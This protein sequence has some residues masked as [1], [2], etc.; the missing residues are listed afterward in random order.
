MHMPGNHWMLY[1]ANGHTGRTILEHAV[2]AGE[3]PVLAGRRREA[4][5]P[6]AKRHGLEFRIFTLDDA[7]AIPMN[8]RGIGTLLLAAGP[9]S[10]TSA[11]A[12]DACLLAGTNYV[13]ITG[14]V[15]IFEAVRRRHEAAVGKGIVLFPGA[16][17][18]VVPSDCLAAALHQALPDAR[19]L[20]LAI[21]IEGEPGPGS[22]KTAIEG[23]ADGGWIRRDGMLLRVPAAWRYARIPFPHRDAWAMTIPWGDLSTAW[24]STGIP[25]IEI[26][27]ATPRPAIRLIRAGRPA[28]RVLRNEAVLRAV[29][30][31][32]DV[33]VTGGGPAAQK[34]GGAWVWG[35]V[36]NEAGRSIAGS[37]T[38]M[39]T[40]S[41]TAQ[42][43]VDIVRRLQ[44]GEVAPGCT[45]PALAFG[46]DYIRRF[47]RTTMTLEEEITG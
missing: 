47:P 34:A 33:F 7:S 16:G 1:G 10:A 4:I 42:T 17:F 38:T 31:L 2:A 21:A 43:T 29:Q 35:R 28:L 20:Q 27:M 13:D 18:D 5:E 24:W 15:A 23:A 36:E 40:T 45:T 3:T 11:P 46:P 37:V 8:L 41:L 30:K 22:I 44:R 32:I 14:E 25:D 39:E 9:F 26:Y 6:L 12:L 19:R